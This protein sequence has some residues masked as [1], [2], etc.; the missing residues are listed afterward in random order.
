[1]SGRSDDLTGKRFGK[2]TALEPTG[3]RKNG[4]TVWRCQCDCGGE[5]LASSRHLKN[6]W[7]VDCGCGPAKTRYRELTGQRF[8]RLLVLGISEKEKTD[9]KILWN[10]VCDC[11]NTVTA[12]SGLLLGGYKK[13]CGCLGRP[14]L[15]DWMGKQFGSLTVLSYG[16][17]SAGKHF[18]KCRCACGRETLVCQS[19]LLG[20]H[21]VSCGC[22]ADPRSTRHFV[23]GT[24]LESIQ[25]RKLFSS[26]TSGVRG[27]YRNR[28]SGRWV[29]QIT[30]QGKTRY[31]GSFDNIQDAARA[32]ADGE[33]IFEEFLEQCASDS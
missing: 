24:C 31:L 21:T 1:M 20:G 14:P 18:W 5:I 11:G 10:C 26:N 23:A 33:R 25:S 8:G 13:S 3:E 6:G 28:K 32:R 7:T 17:K 27:V 30:F 29:A 15:K 19:N 4:Y 9:G 2:L 16:G 22:K 12:S